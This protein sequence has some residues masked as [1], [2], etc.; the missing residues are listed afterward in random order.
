[1]SHEPVYSRQLIARAVVLCLCSGLAL[2]YVGCAQNATSPSPSAVAADVGAE[3]KPES[4]LVD[5]PE[6]LSWNRFPVDTRVV[7][8]REIVGGQGKVEVVTTMTIREKTEKKIVVGQQ[9]TVIRPDSTLENEPQSLEYFAKFPLPGGMKLESFSLP[10]LKAQRTGTEEVELLGNKYQA[11][12][13]EWVEQ[14]ERGPM[15]VKLWRSD[16]V[17]GRTIKEESIVQNGNDRILEVVIEIF[18]PEEKK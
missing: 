11:E 10:S 13:F 12:I 8:R 16:E 18:L 6:Y 17:P 2:V 1:M 3:T 5:N 4:E 15:K 9:I 14:N 7:R